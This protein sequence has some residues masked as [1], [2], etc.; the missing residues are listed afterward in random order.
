MQIH[1]EGQDARGAGRWDSGTGRY[2]PMTGGS[3]SR[4][5]LTQDADIPRYFGY[6]GIN[7]SLTPN[8]STMAQLYG[9][10]G[11]GYYVPPGPEGAFV[12]MILEHARKWH[13]GAQNGEG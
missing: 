11:G 6:V 1:E 8:I 4:L 9:H 2:I 3:R 5:P 12:K 10:L 7:E 13:G